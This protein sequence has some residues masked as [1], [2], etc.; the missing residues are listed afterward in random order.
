VD[1]KTTKGKN[2][3]KKLL[4]LGMSSVFAFGAAAQTLEERVEALEFAGYES[5]FRFSGQLEMRF[6]SV[7]IDN[8]DAYT[9][10]SDLGTYLGS[11]GASGTTT[12]P[13]DE[14]NNG[15]AKM[16][17]RMNMSAQ[18]SDKLSFFGRLSSAKHMNAF[19]AEGTQ[20]TT[21]QEF[22]AG[23]TTRDNASVWLERAFA[24]YK[25]TDNLTMTF[26][27]LPTVGGAPKHLSKGEAMAGAYPTQAY[28]AIFDGVALT[29]S[30]KSTSGATHSGRFVW[31][32]TT[33]PNL[34]SSSPVTSAAGSKMTS[35]N[36]WVAAMYEYENT[37]VSWARKSHFIGQFMQANGSETS[38]QA[39]VLNLQRYALYWEILGVGNSKFDLA[40]SHSINK[41]KNEGELNGLFPKGYLGLTDGEEATG[42]ST[43]IT[44]RYALTEKSKIGFEYVT[45]EDTAFTFDAVSTTPIN[46]YGS[47]G[48]GYHLFYN[49]TFD[50]GLK[51]NVG[52]MTFTQDSTYQFVGLIGDKIEIDKK[53]DALYTGF[54]ADF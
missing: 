13:A 39:L 44:T 23:I 27:R 48:S 43:I 25:F 16:W 28:S 36:D 7:T 54:V 34:E 1:N 9:S 20:N 38:T 10:I 14:W 11:G 37:S 47:F 3:M 29:Y 21:Y 41:L 12:T 6:D 42:G 53:T 40:L 8:K 32:P 15:Y 5:I 45:T 26:G 51:M 22:N 33:T 19:G 17:F 30:K 52:Y 2:I 18:P 46:M 4:V 49:H 31:T 35:M 50:G 24:N